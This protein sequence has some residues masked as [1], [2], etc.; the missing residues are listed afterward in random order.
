MRLEG[1]CPCRFPGKTD[2]H[3]KKL[4]PGVVNWWEV[5]MQHI[6]PRSTRKQE[7]KEEIKRQGY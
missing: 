4:G 3:P 5:D 1:L 7:L 2:C 6:K